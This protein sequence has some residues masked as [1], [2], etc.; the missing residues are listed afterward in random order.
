M[1][2]G[3][4]LFVLGTTGM[5]NTL[6]SVA[7]ATMQA[8]TAWMPSVVDTS[9]QGLAVSPDGSRLF[10]TD[11]MAVGIR[12]FDPTSLRLVQTI[13]WTSEVT[14]PIGVGALPDGSQIFTAN[15]GSGNVGIVQQVQPKG[16]TH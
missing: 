14:L 4:R 10:A 7:T 8:H 15:A 5:N 3:S 13:S 2:D 12:V 16:G 11:G 6:T 1:P 9:L